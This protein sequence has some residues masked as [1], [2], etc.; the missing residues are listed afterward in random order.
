MILGYI[1]AFSYVLFMSVS[2]IWLDDLG[3]SNNVVFMLLVTTFITALAFNVANFRRLKRSYLAVYYD[4]S[5]WLKMS[6]CIALMWGGTYYGTIFGSPIL[7]IVLSI[8]GEALFASIYD[9]KLINS[10]LSI[11]MLFFAV[12]VFYHGNM[13]PIMISIF[14]GVIIFIYSNISEKFARNNKL[15][16][17]DILSTRFWLLL[18]G[19]IIYFFIFHSRIPAAVYSIHACL[20]L[21]TS[22]VS[23]AFLN[24]VIPIFLSQSSVI[25]IGAINNAYIMTLTPVVVFILQWIFLGTLSIYIFMICLITTLWLNKGNYKKYIRFMSATLSSFK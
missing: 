12:F 17:L 18:V 13:A 25:R 3:S 5:T 23:I 14:T 22:L 11:L 16:S 8:L 6:V 4:F 19:C 15:T 24:M 1:Q 10:I 9:K 21:L 20:V 2:L 7:A